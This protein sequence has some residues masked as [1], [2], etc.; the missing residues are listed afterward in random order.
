[1]AD[2]RVTQA[3]SGAHHLAL[4][5][6]RQTWVRA[7]RLWDAVSIYLP[8]L[9]M[10][11]LALGTYWL[12]RN[13]P[14]FSATESVKQVRHEADYFMRKFTVKSFDESGQLKSEIFGVEARHYP[15][16]DTLEIDQARIRSV[17]AAGRVTTSSATRAITN[18]DGSEAQL[19]GNAR[20]VR[21]A[22]RD[23]NGRENPRMEF[24]G[25]FLHAFLNEDRVKSHL[26]VVLTRNGDQFTGDTFAYD[27][28]SG[29][30]EL[31]GRVKGVLLPKT[32]GNAR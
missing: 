14:V 10:G 6:L 13:T 22:S 28:L 23:A 15:D 12:V 2:Q 32:G 24:H 3:L 7:S 18:G 21:E 29:V 25:E 8:L 16:S 19:L 17:D 11:L 5:R 27:N 1:V 9:L 31:K 20:V 26:P 4:R 30:V